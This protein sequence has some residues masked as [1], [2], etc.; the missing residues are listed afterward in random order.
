LRATPSHQQTPSFSVTYSS[1]SKPVKKIKKA[2]QKHQHIQK[3]SIFEKKQ[4]KQ[5]ENIKGFKMLI[6]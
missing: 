4:K 3:N 5:K 1:N 2:S 6:I